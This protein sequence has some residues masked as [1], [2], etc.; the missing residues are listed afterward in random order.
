MIN[1][2]IC[3]AEIKELYFGKIRDGKPGSLSEEKNKVLQCQECEVAFLEK[4]YQDY[5]SGEYRSKYDLDNSAEAY[6][7]N[8]DDETKEKLKY[9]SIKDLRCKKIMDVGAGAGSFLDIFSGIAN[10]ILAI[11][12]DKFYK[13]ALQEKGYLTFSDLSGSVEK[14]KGKLDFVSSFA[15]VEHV[16]DCVDFFELI[17]KHLSKDGIFLLSTPNLNDWLIDFYPDSYRSFYFRTAHKW[18]FNEKSLCFLAK[19]VGFRDIKFYY[20]HQYDFGNTLLWL[21]ERKPCGN[22]KVKMFSELD[23][24]FK[25]CLEKAGKANYIYA[26]LKK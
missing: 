16:S 24:S 1:C 7:R 10:E 8:H 23:S 15:V 13:K 25:K 21:K 20:K 14:F 12:P 4:Y 2:P 11:E 22:G 18:Y 6:Y 9:V 5:V 17:F 3:S 26:V 19:K